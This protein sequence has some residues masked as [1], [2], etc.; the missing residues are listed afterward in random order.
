MPTVIDVAI[1][2]SSLSL[3]FSSLSLSFSLSLSLFRLSSFF[4]CQ[5]I[6]YTVHSTHIDKISIHVCVAFFFRRMLNNDTASGP[7][8]STACIIL[9]LLLLLLMDNYSTRPPCLQPVDCASVFACFSTLNYFISSLIFRAI[10]TTPV[11][12]YSPK[13]PASSESL[14]GLVSF[15][16]QQLDV[17]DQGGIL[18]DLGRVA[19]DSIRQ[20]RR[21]A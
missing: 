17:E 6:P 19:L 2:F 1:P 7:A 18:R 12:E 11:K 4:R 10:S 14:A 8:H 15:D 21:D 13:N 16:R 9:R 3:S 5:S 20:V